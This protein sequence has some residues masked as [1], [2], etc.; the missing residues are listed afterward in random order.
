M[1]VTKRR[2]AQ[3]AH[4]SGNDFRRFAPRF[5][6]I[7]WRFDRGKPGKRADFHDPTAKTAVEPLF[8][9]SGV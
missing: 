4:V 8:R 7:C 6:T 2:P 5:D 1:P 9:P 3:A